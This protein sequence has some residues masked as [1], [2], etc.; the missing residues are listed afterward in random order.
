LAYA[1][2]CAIVAVVLE[3]APRLPR[4]IGRLIHDAGG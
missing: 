2:V 1:I 3:A 4:L